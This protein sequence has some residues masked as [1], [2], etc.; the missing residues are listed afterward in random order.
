MGYT[1][2]YFYEKTVLK[3]DEIMFQ[4]ALYFERALTLQRIKF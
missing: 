3:R 2:L 1:V 4:T